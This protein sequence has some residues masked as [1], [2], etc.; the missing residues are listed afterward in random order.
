MPTDEEKHLELQKRIT[1][2][3]ELRQQLK[4]AKT[5]VDKVASKMSSGNNEEKFKEELG[6]FSD[7]V[8]VASLNIEKL[9]NSIE[10]SVSRA[11]SRQITPRVTSEPTLIIT[12]F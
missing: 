4:E 12:F 5:N 7:A 10:I 2:F 6:W 3:A 8:E 1:E 9:L 11:P